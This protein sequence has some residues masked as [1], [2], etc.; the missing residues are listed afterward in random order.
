VEDRLRRASQKGIDGLFVKGKSKGYEMACGECYR[1]IRRL[2]RRFRPNFGGYVAVTILH[3]PRSRIFMIRAFNEYG[4][5]AYLSENM[6]ETGSL[7]RSIWTGETVILEG[8]KAVG[9]V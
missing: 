9:V 1:R 2:Y 8:D 6:R 7:V 5:S 3:D 4:D